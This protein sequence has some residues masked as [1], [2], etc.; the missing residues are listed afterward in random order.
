[1]SGHDKYWDLVLEQYKLYAELADRLHARRSVSNTFFLTLNAAVFTLIGVFWKDRPQG[2]PWL[3]VVPLLVLLVNCGAWIATLQAYRF[4]NIAKFTVIGAFESQLPA[5]PLWGGEW[6]AVR[7]GKDGFRSSWRAEM[8][9][10][11]LFA[12][13]Y[14]AAFLIA[15]LAT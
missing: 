9:V 14:L 10:P 12:I 4:Q 3:L 1:M 6:E 2:S 5:S 11:I 8:T 7:R 13:A 15:L